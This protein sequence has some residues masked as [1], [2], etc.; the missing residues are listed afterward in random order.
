MMEGRAGERRHG[1]FDAAVVERQ[2]VVLFGL[3]EKETLHAVTGSGNAVA[4]WKAEAQSAAL[5]QP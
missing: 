2:D 1:A 3:G 5:A 4:L